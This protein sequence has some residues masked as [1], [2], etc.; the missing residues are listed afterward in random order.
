MRNL[1]SVILLSLLFFSCS[2]VDE[3]PEV[4]LEQIKVELTT[5]KEIL[6]NHEN[7]NLFVDVDGEIEEARFYLDGLFIGSKLTSPY[8][9]TFQPVDVEPGLRQFKCVV[10][11][12]KG[13]TFTDSISVPCV[14]RIGD[15]YKGGIIYSF[16]IEGQHGLVAQETD[17]YYNGTDRF[18]WADNVIIGRNTD[19]GVRNTKL[20][21]ENSSSSSQVGYIL[22]TYSFNGF[23]DWYIPSINELKEL[24]EMKNIVGNFTTQTNW[25]GLYWSSSELSETNAEATNFNS[26]MGNYYGKNAKSLKVRLI[27]KF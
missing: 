22:K 8:S 7:V 6:H 9:I 24:K 21:S 17:L 1:T 10:D 27:R 20:M 2:K 11:S 26:L 13:G 15:K 19:D 12:K 18:Y 16:T 14:I 4:P 23:S 5:D 3:D 25:E